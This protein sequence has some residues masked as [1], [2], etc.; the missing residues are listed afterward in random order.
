M[1]RV[2]DPMA[3]RAQLLTDRA[4][5]LTDRA[6]L[7]TDRALRRLAFAA[8]A[9]SP[10]L[11]ESV[12]SRAALGL[13][14]ASADRPAPLSLT[15]RLRPCDPAMA[16]EQFLATLTGPL[17]ACSRLGT[18]KVPAAR[19]A[20]IAAAAVDTRAGR[21]CLIRHQPRRGGRVAPRP[22]IPLAGIPMS[23]SWTARR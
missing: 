2:D 1:D 18:R 6:Q 7:L 16:A 9:D 22:S 8:A 5:L 11:L 19:T 10:D 21:H 13:A 12:P 15:G 17:E 3:E 23:R 14:E 4:Q 20:A